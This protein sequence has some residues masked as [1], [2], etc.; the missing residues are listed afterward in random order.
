MSPRALSISQGKWTNYID[1]GSLTTSIRVCAT[2]RLPPV[3]EL[4]N[5]IGISASLETQNLVLPAT[6]T[7]DLNLQH[8][9]GCAEGCIHGY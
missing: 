8:Y 7:G 9:H 3:P 6:I 2:M 5:V 4:F 1:D